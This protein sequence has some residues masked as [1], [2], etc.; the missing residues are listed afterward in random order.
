[1]E[2]RHDEAEVIS[3]LTVTE[4]DQQRTPHLEVL[5]PPPI[6]VICLRAGWNLGGVL[7]TYISVESAGDR[8]V[9]RVRALLPQVSK[10]FCE[11]NILRSISISQHFITFCQ[12]WRK[13]V[14]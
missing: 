14:V 5:T 1:M 2:Q 6:I 7:N 13:R 12:M 10:E 9:G 8:F 4:K 11:P 3:A